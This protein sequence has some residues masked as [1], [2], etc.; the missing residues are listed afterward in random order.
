MYGHVSVN[1]LL[2]QQQLLQ[3]CLDVNAVSLHDF[4]VLLVRLT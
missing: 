3:E 2:A 4:P 1:I